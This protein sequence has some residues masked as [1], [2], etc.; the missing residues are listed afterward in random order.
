MMDGKWEANDVAK[1]V[2]YPRTAPIFLKINIAFRLA[3]F[4]VVFPILIATMFCYMCDELQKCA[5]QGIRSF[6]PC[7]A[8]V[9]DA[10]STVT[11]LHA[12]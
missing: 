5:S 7:L 11:R 3:I 12:H 9:R 6:G 10:E 1:G 2:D 8:T 4:A